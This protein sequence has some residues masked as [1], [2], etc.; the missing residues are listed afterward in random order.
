[1][2]VNPKLSKQK[3]IG[4]CL[5]ELSVALYIVAVVIVAGLVVVSAAPFFARLPK[6][7]G[8]EVSGHRDR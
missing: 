1:M 8:D 7:A 5:I 4:Y 2:K 3:Q 6:D